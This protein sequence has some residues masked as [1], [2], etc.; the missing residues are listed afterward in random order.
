M[1]EA[2]FYEKL[3]NRSARC[4]LCSHYCSI[5]EQKFGFCGVRQNI[6]GILYTHTYGKVIAT[7]VDPV[8]KKPLYHFLPGS[9]SFSIATIGCNFRCGFCQNWE[10]SQGSF[11]DGDI[12]GGAVLSPEEIVKEALRNNCRSISYTYTEPT[13]FF[14]YALEIAKLAKEKGLYNNFITNGYMTKECLGMI[15]PYLD[16]AN[17]DLKFFKDDSYKRICS[18]GLGPVLNSILLM[19]EFGVWL[20]V[21][22]LLVPGENDSKQELEGIANFIVSLDK[23]I[24][25]HVSRFNPDYKFTGFQPTPEKTIKEAVDIGRKAGLKFTYAGNVYGWGNDTLCPVCQKLLIKREVFTVLDYNIKAGKCI[26]CGET[27]PGVFS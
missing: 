7:H 5:E 15:R 12:V 26:Y 1:K 25:W 22:T 2:L 3:K 6:G 21:T 23:N 18:G 14:E 4:Y 16:A 11:R 27:V 17:V 8:E 10:I 13:I 19:H 9:S 24:P 20:E